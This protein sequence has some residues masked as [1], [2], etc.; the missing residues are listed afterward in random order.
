M[1][2]L[3]LIKTEEEYDAA[4]NRI[5]EIFGAEE[6]TPESDEFDVLCLLVEEYEK[7]H[8][9]IPNP[10]PIEAIKFC[11]EEMNISQKELAKIMGDATLVSRILNRKR[12]LNIDSIRKLYKAFNELLP[13]EILVSDYKLST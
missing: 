5:E 3:K 10:D 2:H 9:P 11:M 13:I 4:L 8:Y 1:N 7:K 12:K 6:G